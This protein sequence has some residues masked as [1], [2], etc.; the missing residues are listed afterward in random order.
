[1]AL[2]PAWLV[3]CSHPTLASRQAVPAATTGYV[4]LLPDV[5]VSRN[6]QPAQPT[7]PAR[8]PRADVMAEILAIP[9]G[10][11]NRLQDW[12]ARGKPDPLGSNATVVSTP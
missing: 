6:A 10:D 11:A 4:T 1:L 3:A 5:S 8:D 9:P 2:Y 12:R 7:A